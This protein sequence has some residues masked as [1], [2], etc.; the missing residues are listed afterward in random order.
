MEYT[1][2]YQLPTWAK[3]DRIMMDDFNDMTGKLDTALAKKGNCHIYARVYVGQ[4][5]F[6]ASNPCSVTLPGR[7]TVML[8]ANRTNGQFMLLV[9]GEEIGYTCGGGTAGKVHVT[10]DAAYV[11]GAMQYTA[12]WYADSAG[13]QMNVKS[14]YYSVIALSEIR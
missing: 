4:G 10:W 14:V 5:D 6:G 9:E 7:L 8:I 13:A 12:T 3:E 1:S 11:D 2:N